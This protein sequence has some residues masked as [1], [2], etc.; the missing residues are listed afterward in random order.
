M[1]RANL[2][3]SEELR[4]S[5]VAAQDDRSV[6]WLRATIDRETI[7]L[8]EQR[9]GSPS[10]DADFD[11]LSDVLQENGASFVLFC[12]DEDQSADAAR[13]WIL[14]SWVPDLCRPRDKMLFSSSRENLKRTLGIGYFAH[15]YYVNEFAELTWGAFQQ[16]IAKGAAPLSEAEILAKEE[17]RLEKDTSIRSN[18][19]GEIPFEFLPDAVDGLTAF[20][21]KSVNLLLLALVGEQISSTGSAQ[22]DIGSPSSISSAL[23]SA[24]EPLFLLLR[25]PANSAHP[26]KVVFIYFCPDEANVRSRMI[27]STA[28]ATV[29]SALPSYDIT[30][31][32]V[33]E[34]RSTDELDAIPQEECAAAAHAAAAPAPVVN[35]A[36]KKPAMPGRGKR[37][38]VKKKFVADTD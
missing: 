7:A 33:A 19:M 20:K 1:A 36:V 10:V 9:A 34:A 13:R 16:S 8:L 6:R 26:E 15:E 23:P 25:L 12:E 21:T 24:T 35:T 22:I 32:K 3:V 37:T 17:S 11:A 30:A 29:V 38:M 27:F 2:F 31:E 14:I 5:F 28:K 4:N 18:A